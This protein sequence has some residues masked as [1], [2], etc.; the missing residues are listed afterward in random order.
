MNWRSARGKLPLYIAALVV[1]V[2][3]IAPVAWVFVSSI[4]DRIELYSAPYKHW[5][6][7]QPT[8]A[9]YIQ[10]FPTGPVYRGGVA[11]P[12]RDL[13]LSGLRNSSILSGVSA[14]ILSLGGLLG[15]YVFARMRF[16]GKDA[17][18]YFLM[19][20][21]PLPIWASLTSLYFLMGQF[22]LLDSLVGM[23]ALFVAY[24]LPL[25]I[26]LMRTYIDTGVPREIEEAAVIDGASPL[27]ALFRVVLPVVA[28]GLASVFLVAFLTTWNSFLI[29]VIFGN[30]PSSQPMT[31]VMSFFIGQHD[32]EWES[33]CAATVLTILPPA[34]LA[35][36][37]QRYLVR[38]LAVGAV[39]G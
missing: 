31:V 39:E 30:S 10:L 21:V 6:P 5:I 23:I 9:N 18:F 19:I 3:A 14:V 27:G 34:V 33:M 15:G 37:F 11:L 13:L 28:P 1:V 24:G 29:P 4:S 20:L 25:Y 7:E 22:G 36:F 8:L 16:R 2:V 26:W 17:L 12:S 35:L 38:G 32:I